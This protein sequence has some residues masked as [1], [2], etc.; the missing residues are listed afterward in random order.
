MDKFPN[1]Q[2]LDLQSNNIER[3]EDLHHL[4]AL[5]NLNLSRNEIT[6]MEGL[7]GLRFLKQLDVS[8]NRIRKLEGLKYNMYI[9]ELFINDQKDG[10]LHEFDVDSII[11]LSQSL[12][13]LQ[14]NDNAIESLDPLAYLN[15]LARLEI[16][17]NHIKDLLSLEKP[18]VCMK[19]LRNLD[20]RGNPVCNAD[21]FRD[22]ILMMSLNLEE[23]NYK[24]VLQHE[25]EFLFKFH[26]LR[27]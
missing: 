10:G 1:L 14:C 12:Q 6:K 4:R 22:H 13:F 2:T 11:S 18:L 27:Q 19:F 24:N 15:Y 7:E 8:K 20:M 3:I 25:R 21:K 9:Q 26:N 23:L 16:K 17:N 5:K